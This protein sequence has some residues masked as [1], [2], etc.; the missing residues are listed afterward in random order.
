VSDVSATVKTVRALL[1]QTYHLG[2][3]QRDF[4]WGE[5]E[6]EALLRDLIAA[7]RPRVGEI[8]AKGY[9]LGP[10]MTM[11]RDGKATLIDGQQ[12]LTSLL[13][14]F[15]AL[16]RRLQTAR[17]RAL[18]QIAVLTEQHL[19]AEVMTSMFADPA[20]TSLL[21]ELDIHGALRAEAA[22]DVERNI[23]GRFA[24]VEAFVA[25]R[26]ADEEL[27]GFARWVLDK[28]SLVDIVAGPSHDPFALFDAMNTRGKP[29]RGVD[30]F[31]LFL[32]Q[33]IPDPVA[34]LHALEVWS[35][36]N[37]QVARTGAGAEADFV[38]AWLAARCLELPEPTPLTPAEAR[39]LID[40]SRMPEIDENAYF[41]A[42]RHADYLP[43]LGLSD[44]ERFVET[45]WTD[46]SALFTRV[47]AARKT[48]DPGLPAFYFLEGLG[49]DFD[50]Y[51]EIL[52][53]A[54]HSPE[55][56]DP[57]R[58][59]AAAQFMENIAA[60]FAWTAQRP[61]K[62]RHM[63][64]LKY[65]AARAADQVRG[66][67]LETLCERLIDLQRELK[68]GFSHNKDPHH[69]AN[70]PSPQVRVLIARMTAQ[71]DTVEGRQHTFAL[72]A[73]RQ[74]HDAHDLE[75][76]L[77]KG[78][79]RKAEAAGHRFESASLYREQRERM[80]A[81]VVIP[82]R[83]NK[84]LANTGYGDKRTRY[85]ADAPN[86]MIG[87]LFG[88]ATQSQ[89][90]QAFYRTHGIVFPNA[91]VLDKKALD[92]RQEAYLALAEATWAPERIAEAADLAS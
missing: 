79:K 49:L 16:R 58:L 76:L 59:A 47:R 25:L 34:R 29:L 11:A 17:K 91:P 82:E 46:Y 57:R 2:A 54:A 89:A 63:S 1:R 26:L 45:A 13:I 61:P 43:A 55:A 86:P 8:G 62:G 66:A 27:V 15:I 75:H 85:A 14:L 74:G 4:V 60:R 53:L 20:R 44:A 30:Q 51:D 64:R 68:F 73:S 37:E 5:E 78:F 22:T 48:Y 81:L 69:S 7:F 77:P 80:A 28:V 19:R 42:I 71:L 72:Y 39:K 84:E 52:M 3:Y 31:K 88:G 92:Q 12:R 70:G 21:H 32:G 87:A 41:Y 23:V 50:L 56:P 40:K 35:A 10:M 33:L 38:K 18:D 65:L 36:A 90:L 24:Q 6:V 67:P 83:L 9:F